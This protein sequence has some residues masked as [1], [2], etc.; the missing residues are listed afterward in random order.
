MT[1][2]FQEAGV[3]ALA[4]ILVISAG[5][6][7]T[8]KEGLTQLGAKLEESSRNIAVAADKMGLTQ[9]GAKLEESSRNIAV[10][11]DKIDPIAI[12]RLL[13]ECEKQRQELKR[14]SERIA[15]LK[16][17]LVGQIP[18]EVVGNY[19]NSEGKPCRV[20]HIEGDQFMFHNSDGSKDEL[21]FDPG[22]N[23]FITESGRTDAYFFRET[24]T[25]CFDGA[26]WKP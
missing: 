18:K 10:A 23:A 26:F 14:Q 2:F 15:G 11:A 1:K 16:A 3:F 21:R 24:R 5:C 7:E 4:A 20:E 13:D 17:E 12:N 9:L 25:I 19:K 6:S 8:G 22:R